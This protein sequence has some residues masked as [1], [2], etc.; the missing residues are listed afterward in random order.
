MSH[1][2]VSELYFWPSTGLILASVS[3]DSRPLGTSALKALKKSFE[4]TD[5]TCEA[6]LLEAAE[7]GNIPLTREL[8]QTYVDVNCIDIL[9]LTPL[10]LAVQNEH[11][12]IIELILDK[13][14]P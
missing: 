4:T 7:Y 2:Q 9:G 8:L 14:K 3:V 5:G 11:F 12:E 6:R 10:Q 1:E 13:S